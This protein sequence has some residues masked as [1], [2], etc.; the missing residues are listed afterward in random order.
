[1]T[2]RDVILRDRHAAEFQFLSLLKH[3]DR[4]LEFVLCH[5]LLQGSLEFIDILKG[6]IE[7]ERT[8]GG[9]QDLHLDIFDVDN[10]DQLKAAG[11][12]LV[13]IPPVVAP[14]FAG[15]DIE[16]TISIHLDLQVVIRDQLIN[17][18]DR[19]AHRCQYKG[20]HQQEILPHIDHAGGDEKYR[21]KQEQEGQPA[22]PE[23]I[24]TIFCERW[25]CRIE[26]IHDDFLLFRSIVHRE[27]SKPKSFTDKLSG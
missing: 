7:D 25:T 26:C 20:D 5:A 23:K 27:A 4:T 21:Q 10:A 13:D 2:V 6:T 11:P 14:A 15:V 3:G 12:D 19:Y 16:E 8:P 1:M 24:G 22:K 17:P 9:I 18:V